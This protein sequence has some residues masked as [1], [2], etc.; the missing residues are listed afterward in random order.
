M[1]L[2][3]NW[4]QI[5]H[6]IEA[7]IREIK[8]GT[9]GTDNEQWYSEAASHFRLIKNAWRNHATHC[10]ISYDEEKAQEIFE[11]VRSFMRHLSTKI[12]E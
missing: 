9:H 5:I 11:S 3:K 4:N 1:F 12:A 2:G 8:K 10:R 7:K 6:Q